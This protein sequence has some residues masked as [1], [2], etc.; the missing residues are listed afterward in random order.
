MNRSVSNQEI[1]I[2]RNPLEAAASSLPANFGWP[3]VEGDGIPPPTFNWITQVHS[4]QYGKYRGIWYIKH[5]T[6]HA[7]WSCMNQR[8]TLDPILSL[9]SRL[10]FLTTDVR[11]QRRQRQLRHLQG[12]VC[13]HRRGL[14]G[15][16]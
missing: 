13:L 6:T 11:R 14:G 3:C 2:L 1:N 5:H 4:C 7:R 12:S 9:I 10:L 8:A 16:G 15:R